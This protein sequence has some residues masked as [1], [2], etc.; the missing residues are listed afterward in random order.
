MARQAMSRATAS[1]ISASSHH[2][3][4]SIAV[5]SVAG[6]LSISAAPPAGPALV[7]SVLRESVLDIFWGSHTR[8]HNASIA[9]PAIGRARPVTAP[10]HRG[11]DRSRCDGG[12]PAR[13]GPPSEARRS[14]AQ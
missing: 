7:H 4:L 5:D 3:G 9:V 1:L 12:L 6:P 11:V 8:C 10:L 13:R 14:L 2:Y